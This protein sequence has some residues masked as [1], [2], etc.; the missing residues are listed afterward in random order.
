[1]EA[2]H[3]YINTLRL[4]GKPRLML[5]PNTIVLLSPHASSTTRWAPVDTL[6]P[7]PNSQDGPDSPLLCGYAKPTHKKGKK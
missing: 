1:M 2:T 4:L 3:V 6:R 7:Q 5:N